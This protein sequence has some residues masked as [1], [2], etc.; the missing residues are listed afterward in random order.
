VQTRTDE[1]RARGERSRQAILRAAL[2]TLG[3]EGLEGFSARNVA[4]RAGV[5]PA[6]I[7][8]HFATL[9]ELQLDAIMLLVD[10]A[11]REELA[12]PPRSVRGYLRSLGALSLRVL[13]EQPQLVHISNALFGKLPFSAPLRARARK[14]Y[15]RWV[16][17]ID[18]KLAALGVRAPERRRHLAMALVML[19]DGMGIHW[20]V[21]HDVEEL[22][23]VWNTLADGVA[24]QLQ[25]PR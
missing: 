23:R 11:L 18:G 8:H 5:S 4:G 17:E 10:Q 14:H 22:E 3:E 6:T 12:Q 2:A 19:L 7:F 9:D 24:V 21:H 1:R 25:P 15:A 13:R 16:E 20:S